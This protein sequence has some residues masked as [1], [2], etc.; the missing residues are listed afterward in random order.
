MNFLTLNNKLQLNETKYLLFKNISIFFLLI[1]GKLIKYKYT[2]GFELIKGVKTL[3]ISFRI[4]GGNRETF[5]FK[6][7]IMENLNDVKIVH[8][9]LNQT[10]IK[11]ILKD[12]FETPWFKTMVKVFYSPHFLLKIFLF[13]FI[14]VCT[15]YAS[16]LTIQ[17]I[18]AYLDFGVTT[19][20][21]IYYETPMLFPRAT[22]CNLNKFTTEYAYNLLTQNSYHDE[23][24]KL[25]DDE[26]KRLAHNFIDILLE[27]EFNN[28]PCFSTDF[29]WSFD[30]FYGNCYTFNT[31]FDSNGNTAELK[32]SYIAGYKFG[33]RLILYVNH[34]EKLS[35]NVFYLGALVR[36]GNSS[37]LNDDSNDGGILLSPGTLT[38]IPIAREFKYLL[39]KPFSNC[40]LDSNSLKFIPGQEL[41]NLISQSGYLYT[42]QFCFI[43]CYQKFLL[44][45][46]N[47]TRSEFFS[48]F[49]TSS[50]SLLNIYF[51][52]DFN[53]AFINKRCLSS[54][55]LECEQISYKTSLS[56]SKLSGDGYWATSFPQFYNQEIKSDFLNR[57]LNSQTARESIVEVNIY[58]E[59]LS[60]TL[61][62]ES[63]QMDGVYLMGSIGGNLGLFLGISVFS[64]CEVIEVA[65]EI[66]LILRKRNSIQACNNA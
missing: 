9:E 2:L 24:N 11:A 17:S 46:H 31:G 51:E 29:T 50:C 60:Y 25:S 23:V 18:M 13:L 3:D 33:L 20:T 39:P 56:F 38:Y 28:N 36:L 54:C 27:C 7:K 40:E 1:V 61:T 59:S 35:E 48:L 16:Y 58:Y 44:D 8:E 45:T 49:N 63:P 5:I 22:F 41:Y 43:Q 12:A 34:Y 62:T 21:R 55:P 4:F 53:D 65:I 42:Q 57:S 64:I 19:T 6:K 15:V 37:Y 66:I 47:C 14:I 10:N 32:K 30:P 26:K 52:E